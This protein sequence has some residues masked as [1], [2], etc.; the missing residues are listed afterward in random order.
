MILT[1]QVLPAPEDDAEDVVAA[2]RGLLAELRETD[3]TSVEPMRSEDALDGAKGPAALIG[4]L[5]ARMQGA[6]VLEPF[7]QAIADWARRSKRSVHVT[8]GEDT[9][10]LSAATAE[11]QSA[12]VEAWLKT[13]GSGE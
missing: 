3:A 12:I 9:L 4:R 10:V 8:L 2:A 13:H 1:V 5:V 6:A 7:I 11:Q